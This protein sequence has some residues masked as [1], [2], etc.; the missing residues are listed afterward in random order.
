LTQE[1]TPLG[2][3]TGFD[4]DGVG[5]LATITRPDGSQIKRQ[6]D[7][8]GRV[9]RVDE[10]ATGSSPPAKTITYT[11][12]ADGRVTGYSDGVTTGTYAFDAVGRLASETV[13]YGTFSAT[14]SYTYYDNGLMK[15][16]T[17]PAGTVSTYSYDSG[18]RL[19][20]VSV[21][22]VGE[23]SVTAYQG[24]AIAG[25]RLP[26]GTAMSYTLDGYQ[27]PTA[28]QSVDPSN[29]TLLNLNLGYSDLGNVTTRDD[30]RG[31]RVLQYDKARR[32]RQG[33]SSSYT[34]DL[35][36]NRLTDSTAGGGTWQYD[37]DD[38]LLSNG[39]NTYAY[40]D[41]GALISKTGAT[42]S[43]AYFYDFEGRLV[44]VTSGTDVILYTY[45]PD[46]RRLSKNVNGTVTYFSYGA[47]GLSA[48]FDSNSVL[49]R[50]YGYSPAG[51]VGAAPLFVKTPAGVFFFHTDQIGTP[52]VLAD[53]DGNIVWKATYND[54][55]RALINVNLVENNLRFPGQYF[56]AETG[57]GYNWSR[58][59]DPEVGRYICLRQ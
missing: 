34:Y 12:D 29:R 26:G 16:C 25:M 55:G 17:S 21:A 46:G 22:G 35:N 43:W 59:Y 44:R 32:L 49:Q 4:Y 41:N 9:N 39:Q 47:Y 45:G 13:N 5:N 14:N 20:G 8:H 7:S 24:N 38:R 31:L 36:H 33:V 30:G 2:K 40:D 11:R 19:L 52:Q 1:K 3:I 37:S 50:E 58:Y 48:E 54:F 15:T 42:R 27:R 51:G 10:C 56:D 6:F 57:L 23:F 18:S 28:I 53:A